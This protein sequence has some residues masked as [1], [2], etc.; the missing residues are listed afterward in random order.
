[1]SDAGP[2]IW[3]ADLAW[4]RTRLG[5]ERDLLALVAQLL[6]RS[7]FDQERAEHANAWPAFSL[8]ERAAGQEPVEDDDADELE[9]F[10]DGSG[11]IVATFPELEP[12]RIDA[13]PATDW[14]LVA[15]FPAASTARLDL[16]PPLIPLLPPGA[17]PAILQ[18]A[19]GIRVADAEPDIPRMVERI[20]KG[21]PV[22]RIARRS[23]STVRFGTQVLL[24][25]GEAMEPFARDQR[26]LADRIKGL[27]G[28]DGVEL[29]SFTDAP[30]R[31]VRR[32]RARVRE[33]YRPPAPGTRVLIVSDLGSGGR[34]LNPLRADPKEWLAFV[35]LLERAQC[36]AVA[37]V[38]FPPERIPAALVSRLRI[39]T[40]DR[41]TGASRA[42]K[43]TAR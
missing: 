7:G 13:V 33:P 11:D 31:G 38:P 6:L 41:S 42:A 18:A 24:D 20:A 10:D 19:L 36:S 30:L 16:R 1:M 35:D 29:V 39:L 8:D 34:A 25:V 40:W 37:L 2:E 17:T 5:G 27:V 3:L 12:I 32:G 28:A 26:E 22:T 23:R 21:M 15:S 14:R 43:A 9:P 4:A